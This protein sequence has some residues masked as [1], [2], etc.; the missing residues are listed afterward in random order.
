[1]DIMLYHAAIKSIGAHQSVKK[2]SKKPYSQ[3]DLE[4][5]RNSEAKP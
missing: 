4:E 3:H 2:N 1:M 5:R